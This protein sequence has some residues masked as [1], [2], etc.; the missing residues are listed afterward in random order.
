VTTLL[1]L[2]SL[3]VQHPAHIS[4][5][6]ATTLPAPIVLE[7]DAQQMPDALVLIALLR[8]QVADQK[9]LIGIL[10]AQVASQTELADSCS[11]LLPGL[12]RQLGLEQQLREEMV[13]LEKARCS[14][15]PKWLRKVNI[16]F[17]VVVGGLAGRGSCDIR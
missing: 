9:K 5:V 8:E 3:W 1:L 4:G 11:G 10:Q 2:A 15:P 7:S 13:S 6:Y 16:G 14:C 17:G 12:Q